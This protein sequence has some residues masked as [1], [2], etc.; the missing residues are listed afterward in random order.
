MKYCRK[1]VQPDTRPGIYFDENG[2]CGACLYEEEKKTIDW[3]ARLKELQNIA[4]WAKKHTDSVYDCAIGVSGGKD[5]T[6]QAVY[7]RDTLGLNPLLVSWVPDDLT[8]SGKIQMDNIRNLG[9]DVFCVRPNPVLMK[10]LTKKDFYKHMNP[11]KAGEHCLCAS[12]NLI[13]RGFKIPLVIQGEN[14]ALTLGVRNTGLG[15]GGN[16]LN[17]A[18]LQTLSYGLEEYMGDGVTEKD[19]FFYSYDKDAMLKGDFKGVWIQYYMKEWSFWGNTEFAQKYGLK[20]RKGHDPEKCGRINSYGSTDS[21]MQILNQMLKYYKLGFGFTTD[22]VCY[23]IREGRM[24][25]EEAIDLVEKYDGKCGNEYIEQFCEYL[26]I[27][28]DEFWRV[29]DKFVNKDL[30][31]KDTA[32]DIWK[33]KF[34]V[35]VDFDKNVKIEA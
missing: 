21:N 5:S 2:I 20:E 16:A 22:E 15:M 9:F 35:G 10:K 24:T 33:P 32:A 6:L 19:L 3:D 13:A 28:K 4:E 26:D 8:D 23:A 12:T 11:I 30:F 14:P 7:A 27:T 17:I 18:G 29:V 25:R 34:K 31:E 1:C